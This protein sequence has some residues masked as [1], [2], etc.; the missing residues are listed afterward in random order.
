MLRIRKDDQ[1]MMIAGKD[2]GKTGRVIKVFREDERI[3]VENI[4]VVKKTQRKSQQNP[5]GGF[6]NIEVPVHISNVQLVDKKMNKPTRYSVSI[7]KDG[8]KVR[9]SKKSQEVV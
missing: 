2:K 8:A 9:L 4:N 1:V 5:Q 6:T 7:L 3:L